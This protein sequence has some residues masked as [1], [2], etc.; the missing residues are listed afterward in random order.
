[1]DGIG[2]VVVVPGRRLAEAE[3]RAC[4]SLA[5]A[6]GIL[7]DIDLSGAMTLTVGT[8]K[9]APR[10]RHRSRLPLKLAAEGQGSIALTDEAMP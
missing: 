4:R 5:A 10:H 9:R 8:R 2:S 6:H 7:L 1:M 3:A